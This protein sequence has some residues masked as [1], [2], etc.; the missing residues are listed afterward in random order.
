MRAA[1]YLSEKKA[2]LPN[3]HAKEILATL[4]ALGLPLTLPADIDPEV[5]LKKTA[6]DKKFRSGVIRFV[7]LRKAGEAFVSNDITQQ[8]LTEAIEELRKPL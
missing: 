7:L 5:V 1:L 4:R 6:S 3:K 2:G 8:D